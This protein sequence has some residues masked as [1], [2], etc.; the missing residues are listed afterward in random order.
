MLISLAVLGPSRIAGFSIICIV[1]SACSGDGGSSDMAAGI[2][3]IVVDEGAAVNADIEAV[4]TGA[5]TGAFILDDYRVIV[6]DAGQL[7]AVDLVEQAAAGQSLG[8][9]T[10]VRGAAH[11]SED[12]LIVLTDDG[13]WVW[14]GVL[15]PS[16]LADVVDA[17][18]LMGLTQ[19]AAVGDE[20]WLGGDD[21]LALWRDGWL[22]DLTLDGQP[23]HAPFATGARVAGRDAVWV[24]GSGA[25]IAGAGFYALTADGDDFAVLD[26]LQGAPTAMAVSADGSLWAAVEGSLYHY[27][28]G[29]GWTIFEFPEAVETVVAN[30][31]STLTTSRVWVRT[32]S[33]VFSAL[34]AGSSSGGA[35][36]FGFRRIVGMDG[37]WGT[38]WGVDDAGRLIVRRAD[39]VMRA[40]IDRPV[41]IR[42]LP[43]DGLIFAPIEVVIAPTM[44]DSVVGVDLALNGE[45]I[46]TQAD[47]GRYRATVDPAYVA[48]GSYAFD[49][50][51]RY[52]D[53]TTSASWELI[54]S[55]PTWDRDILPLYQDHCAICHA[56][57]TGTAPLDSPAAWQERFDRL[58]ELVDSDSM[59]L[60][61]TPLTAVQKGVIRA[62]GAK[63][64]P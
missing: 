25:G 7:S 64:F 3:V 16:P 52:D 44:S 24:S 46:A 20:L 34:V 22:H 41:A 57:D 12:R 37:D 35:D 28:D 48:A 60:G 40:A 17:A 42:G 50:A 18:E 45:A 9:G 26:G 1:L 59:P 33:H 21:T 11:W 14:D 61:R 51:V 19:V 2:D 54:I 15:R 63:G 29:D 62:W 30:G 43:G 10:A 53:V 31:V 32:Q 55:D 8:P 36:A 56:G 49:L 27:R 47:A 23:A 39:G 4:S 13:L 6:S 58:L 38:D 5:P